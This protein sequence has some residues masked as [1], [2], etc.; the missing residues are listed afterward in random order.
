[1]QVFA[2]DDDGQTEVL[3]PLPQHVFGART[4]EAALS[5]WASPE[6]MSQE[7]QMQA[8]VRSNLYIGT[9]QPWNLQTGLYQGES[10]FELTDPL[11][12]PRPG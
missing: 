6:A 2:I 9:N 1:M 3:G 4:P 7:T 11:F 10:M 8:P 12:R 5:S